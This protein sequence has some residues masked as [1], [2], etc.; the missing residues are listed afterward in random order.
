MFFLFQTHVGKLIRGQPSNCIL[1]LIEKNL[2]S[3]TEY[4][5]FVF[6]TPGIPEL[7]FLNASCTLAIPVDESF[8]CDFGKSVFVAVSIFDYICQDTISL[9]YLTTD[10]NNE[11]ECCL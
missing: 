5:L 10:S 6:E 9:W 2:G 8:L 4:A 3:S 1:A 7:S 11:I